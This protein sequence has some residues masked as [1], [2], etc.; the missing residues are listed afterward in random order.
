MFTPPCAFV[1][2]SW[3]ADALH[4]AA[5][6]CTADARFYNPLL[7]LFSRALGYLGAIS[8]LKN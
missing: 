1:S 7:S 2:A 3:A 8:S 5:M 6:E 4:L